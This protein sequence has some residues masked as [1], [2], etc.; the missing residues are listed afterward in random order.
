MKKMITL[1]CGLATVLA[2]TGAMAQGTSQTVGTSAYPISRGGVQ[3][4]CGIEFTHIARDLAYKGGE[5]VVL[6][7]S[8][9][10]RIVNGNLVLTFKLMLDDVVTASDGE[11]TLKPS[12]PAS[13]ALYGPNGTSN[14]RTQLGTSDGEKPGTILTIYPIDDVNGGILAAI[15]EKHEMTISYNRLP[16]GQDVRFKVDLDVPR[17]TGEDTVADFRKCVK[18]LADQQS[19]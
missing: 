18:D 9:G 11:K 3:E 2:S 1:L 6:N 4:G 16:G 14:V 17:V 7:G 8:F 13:V 15:S 5:A 12:K 10:P 19:G